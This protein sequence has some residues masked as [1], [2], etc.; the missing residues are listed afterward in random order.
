MIDDFNAKLID[1]AIDKS[2]GF[3]GSSE[4]VSIGSG[5]ILNDVEFA[6]FDPAV[7]RFVVI[8]G[9]IIVLSHECDLDGDNDRL[10]NDRALICP[11]LSISDLLERAKLKSFNQEKIDTFLVNLVKRR[12][13]RAIFFPPLSDLPSGGILYL[14]EITSTPVSRLSA[15]NPICA[16]S[17]YG[18]R[19][20]DYSLENHL[21]RPKAERLPYERASIRSSHSIR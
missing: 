21:R 3:Y 10:L 17:A 15:A 8:S 5:L 13:S 16:V 9:K 6:T 2:S 20:I 18:M 11:V 1:S 12:V 14:N 19:V 7:D 4:G